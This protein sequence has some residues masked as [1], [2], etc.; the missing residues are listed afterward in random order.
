MVRV[1]AIS[2]PEQTLK[3]FT[4]WTGMTLIRSSRKLRLISTVSF[5]ES[6]NTLVIPVPLPSQNMVGLEA[7]DR[8]SQVCPD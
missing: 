1:L 4:C 5:A 6:I 7:T 2:F 3:F 8:T